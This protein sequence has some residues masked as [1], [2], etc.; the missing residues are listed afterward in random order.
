MGV[1]TLS[2][3]LGTLPMVYES[4]GARLS[5]ESHDG[6]GVP[7]STIRPVR[8]ARAGGAIAAA[9]WDTERYVSLNGKIVADT[10]AAATT[11]RD[12]VK[13]A[14]TLDDTTLTLVEGD[15]TRYLTVRRT[16]EFLVSPLSGHGNNM[17]W[18]G[19]MVA[20]DPRLRGDALTASTG[21]PASTGGWTFPL[22]LPAPINAVSSSGRITLTNDGNTTGKVAIRITAGVGGITGPRVTHV[23]SGKSLVFATSLTIAED[24]W[25]DVDMEAHTVLENGTASRNGWVTGRGWSGFAPGD[26]QWVFGAV[27]GLGTLS[28]T[29]TPSWM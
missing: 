19:Q 22:T 26:N 24:N 7:A 16:G 12:L 20:L 4:S 21:L 2:M 3:T 11:M 18:S 23:A 1:D 14:F 28:V 29:A 25:V 13:S 9:A 17:A 8:R 10:V 27:S 5:L 15:V 6:F